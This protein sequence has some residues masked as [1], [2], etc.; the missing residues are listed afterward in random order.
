MNP[1]KSNDSSTI[2]QLDD[3]L[4][5]FGYWPITIY[6]YQIILP[7][8][9]FIGCILCT[10]SLWIFYKKKFSA[11]IYWYFRVITIDNLIQLL[12]AI[13]YGICTTP[14][15]FPDMDSYACALVQCAYLPFLAFTSH[16]VAILQIA[17]L[18]ERIKIMNLFV[19]KHFTISPK[20]M[21]L[22]TFFPCASLISAYTLLYVPYFGGDFYYSVSNGIQRV[23]G[24]WFVSTS[25]L[26]QSEIGSIL[27]IALL[28]VKDILTLITTITLNIV[29]LIELK[30]YIKNV[31]NEIQNLKKKNHIKLILIMCSISIVERIAFVIANVYFLF[32]TD[33][34]AYLLG[35]ISDLAFVVGA[36]ISF[37]VFYNFNK[38]FKGEFFIL[39]NK[40]TSKIK[41]IPTV[42]ENLNEN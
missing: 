26:A 1:N 33:Y 30:N 40:F 24:F 2:Y 16:F 17:I 11:P 21:I 14:K 34:V 7:I 10:L 3:L 4:F 38:D 22:I 32:S 15:Y 13:P 28:F 35:A 25:T 23:N 8:V 9:A 29:S 41:V 37:F 36:S 6:M 20:K 12:F 39:A 5:S 31:Q 18:F 27:M 42:A 19:K